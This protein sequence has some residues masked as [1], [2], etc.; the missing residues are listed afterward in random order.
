MGILIQFFRDMRHWEAPVRWSFWV[1]LGLLAALLIAF[2]VGRDQ[3]PT[4]SLAGLVALALVLQGI[5]LYGNRHLVTPYTQAQRAFRNGEFAQA[6]AILEQH[7]AEQSRAGK[8]VN[9]DVYVL[10]GNALRNLAELD[11]SERVLRRIVEQQ[12][13]YG[14][15]LYGLGRTLLVKGEYAEAAQIIKKSLLLGAPKAVSFEMGYA[16]LE[17]GD[18]KTGQ[19]ILREAVI[20][21]DEPYRKLMAYHL[22][23][24]LETLMEPAPRSMAQGLAYWEREAAVFANTPYGARV[25]EHVQAMRASLERV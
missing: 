8:T 16:T 12:P 7:I 3:V 25:A 10:L 13:D 2:A 15:A 5:A 11:E 4:W 19:E 1:A 18:A 21:A 20:H 9:A 22:L 17:S 14:F 24:G 6:R 23:G